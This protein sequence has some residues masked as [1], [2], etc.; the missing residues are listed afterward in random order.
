MSD[1]RLVS[2]IMPV[3]NGER[4]LGDAI[5]SV[6]GQSH[7]AIQ[8]IVVDDGSS[9]RSGEVARGFPE[10]EYHRKENGGVGTARNLALRQVRGEFIAFL[11]ADDLWEPEKLK[12][13]LEWM[14]AHPEHGLVFAYERFFV[15]EGAETPA[16][17]TGDRMQEDH[18]AF[19]PGTLLVRRE[20]AQRVGDFVTHLHHEDDTE[21]FMRA[22]DAGFG[23]GIMKQTLLHRRIHGANISMQAR[24]SAQVLFKLLKDSILRQR[25]KNKD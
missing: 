17:Y 25:T 2:I 16:W 9:D 21:W 23:I 24:P 11:D 7:R 3:C 4:F 19:V 14:D 12:A 13:Q 5:R 18:V 8:L 20:V 22:K 10:V 1:H 15:T 6:L